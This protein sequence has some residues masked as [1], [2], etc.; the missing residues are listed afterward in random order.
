VI[1]DVNTVIGGRVEIGGSA[2]VSDKEATVVGWNNHI[3]DGTIIGSGCTLYPE[4]P[5][6]QWRSHIADGEVIR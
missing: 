3:P 1:C 2:P 5:S 4:L 6:E